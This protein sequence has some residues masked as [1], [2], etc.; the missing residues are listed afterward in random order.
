MVRGINHEQYNF[1]VLMHGYTYT[2]RMYTYHVYKV[3]RLTF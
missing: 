2:I 1:T 3:C